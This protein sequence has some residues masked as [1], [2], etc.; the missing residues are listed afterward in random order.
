MKTFVIGCLCCLGLSLAVSAQP[1]L[2][3]AHCPRAAAETA[4]AILG[5]WLDDKQTVRIRVY[6]EHG[7]YHAK[8]VWLKD[9]SIAPAG[10]QVL[11]NLRH[12]PAG[13]WKPS[14]SPASI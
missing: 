5:D 14:V 11:R 3:M 7:Q 13:K 12:D 9:A 6:R 4:D 1:N 8:I 10:T 2:A